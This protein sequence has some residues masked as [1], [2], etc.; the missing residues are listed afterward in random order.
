M[1]SE[2]DYP[3]LVIE[4]QADERGRINLG[5]D[6]AAETVKVAVLDSDD[7]AE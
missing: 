5:V 1:T 6:Y 4:R 2:S 7:G 3:Q